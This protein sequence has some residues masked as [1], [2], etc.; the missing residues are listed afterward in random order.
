LIKGEVPTHIT[1]EGDAWRITF[2]EFSK[3]IVE[4]PN[5]DKYIQINA[6]V[7]KKVE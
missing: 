3:E 5:G 4:S 6:V 2:D 1:I 7:M